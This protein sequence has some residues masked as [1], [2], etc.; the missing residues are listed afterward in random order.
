MKFILLLSTMAC[1]IVGFTT[2]KT[3]TEPDVYILGM[4]GTVWKNGTG[5]PIAEGKLIARDLFVDGD[6]VYVVGYEEVAEPVKDTCEW[7]PNI[8]PRYWKNGKA[9]ALPI[10]RDKSLPAEVKTQRT[11]TSIHVEKG[12]VYVAGDDFEITNPAIYSRTAKYWK[13]GKEI[14]LTNGENM[15]WVNAIFVG[16]KEVHVVGVLELEPP[17][18]KASSPVAMY[19]KNGEQIRLSGK[20]KNDLVASVY[21][22][23]QDVYV[24]GSGFEFPSIAKYWKNG[25]E[26]L[27]TDGTKDASASSVFVSGQDVYVAGRYGDKAVIWK[28]GKMIELS[29]GRSIMD[30]NAIYVSGNDV[31]VVGSELS[32]ALDVVTARYWKNGKQ[33]KLSGNINTEAIDVFVTRP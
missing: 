11:L 21:V 5:K 9:I 8:K 16:N 24:A 12:D 3:K 27:L 6:D 7:R 1:L 26:V 23:G 33:I 25:K 10:T 17:L 32:K 15:K 20:N 31:Y 4:N 19:W 29:D 30:A 22:S 2:C 28:N 13:N 14:R 18:S